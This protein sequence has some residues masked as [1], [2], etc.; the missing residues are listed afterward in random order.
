VNLFL[1]KI[2]KV[3]PNQNENENVAKSFSILFSK[4]GDFFK[5]IVNIAT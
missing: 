2:K 1:G 4:F 3:L 5:E